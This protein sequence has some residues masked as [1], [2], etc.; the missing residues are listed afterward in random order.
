[1]RFRFVLPV[2]ELYASLL[3]LWAPWV[4]GA[5]KLDITLRDGREFKGYTILPNPVVFDATRWAQALNLPAIL[6][7]I[8]VDL[9]TD[10]VRKEPSIPDPRMRF[11]LFATLGVGIWYFLGRF[12]EDLLHL[13][14]TGLLLRPRLMDTIFAVEATIVALLAF[15]AALFGGP[16]DLLLA[17]SSGIW[18]V[19]ASGVLTLRLAQFVRYRKRP[20]TP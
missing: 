9:V 16:D 7:E 14:H 5:H 13:S 12:M 1:M 10:A 18:W 2:V 17:W 19:L 4:P 8:P 20:A 11:F 3:I 15:L 6:A